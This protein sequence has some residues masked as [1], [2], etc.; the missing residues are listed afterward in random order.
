MP[1]VDQ[2]RSTVNLCGDW[3]FRMDPQ[4]MGQSQ[5]WYRPGVSFP[6]KIRVPGAWN[7]QG[8]GIPSDKPIPEAGIYGEGNDFSRLFHVFPGPGWYRRSITVPQ[9]WQGKTLWLKFG[10]VHRNADVWLNGTYLG[11]HIGYLTP[12]K[13]DV[14]R[15]VKPGQT[16]VLVV[17]VDARQRREIDPLHGCFD[18]LEYGAPWGGIYRKVTLEATGPNWIEDVFVVPGLDNGTAEIRATVGKLPA[19]ADAG[20]TLHVRADVYEPDGKLAVEARAW[21]APQ[22]TATVVARIDCAR[23]WSPRDPQLYTAHVTLLDGGQPLDSISV[24]FGMREFKVRDGRFWLNGQPFFVRGY[25]DDCVYPNTVAPPADQEEYRRRFKIAKD[26]GFN[27]VRH[28]SWVPLEEYFEV[29]DE[30]GI[31]LQPEFPIG[32]PGVLADTPEGKRLYLD[33]WEGMIKAHRN[34]PSIVTWCMSNEVSWS[35]E[36]NRDLPL[37]MYRVAKR[38]DPTRLVIDTDGCNDLSRLDAETLDFVSTGFGADERVLFGYQDVKYSFL[39]GPLPRKSVIA[40]EMGYFVTL[41]DLNQIELF[42]G[43]VR[44]YWL[45]KARDMA[46]AKGV[47]DQYPKWLENSYRLQAVCLKTNYEAARRAPGLSG[48]SQWLLQDFPGCAEGVVDMFFRPKALSAAEFRKFNAPTVLLMDCPRRNFRWGD[49]V[50]A[51]LLVSRYEDKPSPGAALRWELRAGN[52]VLAAGTKR[53]LRVSCGGVQELMPLDLTLPHRAGAQKLTLAAELADENGAIVNDWSLWAFPKELFSSSDRKL[54]FRGFELLRKYYPWAEA[55]PASGKIADCDLLVSSG[56]DSHV[57]EYLR[58]GGRVLLLAPSPAFAVVKTYMFRPASWVLGQRGAHVGTAI[59]QEHPTMRGMPCE[60][61]CDLQF[62]GLVQGSTMI[63]L[64]ELPVKIRPII[65]SIDLAHRMSNRG[66]LFEA[67][68]GK[69]KLLVSG[70]NFA[71]AL[72]ADDPADAYPWC[73]QRRPVTEAEHASF[74]GFKIPP[75]CRLKPPITPEALGPDDPA[76]VY[77]FDQLIRYALGSEFSPRAVLDVGYLK[78]KLSK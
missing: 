38:L 28:H 14:S 17:R 6:Q 8:I 32:G 49:T 13:Y 47:L 34:H 22:D 75:G 5:Q 48:Y 35:K 55:R 42:H 12:F 69:G 66:Y 72:G 19:G 51:T 10:G 70:L 26:Y 61:W 29:A 54:C 39:H 20:K 33:Q 18:I 7:A 76:G 63:C 15:W 45:Y 31:L 59:E 68:V 41:S 56:F 64:D 2:P 65:R 58:D 77:L 73:R 25:G 57:L 50:K 11:R 67:A 9:D 4:D 36:E 21:V 30:V 71:V 74:S 53:G 37:V 46:R 40:H 27:Y 44:P 24:R 60:G 52:E 1:A 23:L 3:E 62:F 16:A 78:S 43:G